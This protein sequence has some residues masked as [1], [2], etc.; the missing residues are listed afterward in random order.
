VI[1]LTG[2]PGGGKSTLIAELAC[3][4]V[5]TGHFVTLPEAIHAAHLLDVLPGGRLFELA[6]VHLRTSLEDD[7]QRALGSEGPRVILCHR[8]SLDSLAYWLRRGWPEAEFFTLT[9]TQRED[10]Y[11]RYRAVIHLVTAADGAVWAYK[12][13]PEAHRPEKAADAI[14]IDRLLQRVWAD[15]PNYFRVDNQGRDWRSKSKAARDIMSML[16]TSCLGS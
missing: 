16:L 8:G 5:W 1:V 2:G 6:M 12:R 11:R 9:G 15:H 14:H 10:H 7:L 13:W 4:P 3:D